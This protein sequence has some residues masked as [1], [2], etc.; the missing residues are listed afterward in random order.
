MKTIF[1]RP[2]FLVDFD[3]LIALIKANFHNYTFKMATVKH[4]LL[5]DILR[6]QNAVHQARST[7]EINAYVY[8]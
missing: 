5:K 6:P 4:A 1:Y 2:L 7:Y 8:S 3:V